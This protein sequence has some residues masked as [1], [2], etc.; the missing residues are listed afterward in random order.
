MKKSRRSFVRNLAAGALAAGVLP[1]IASAEKVH[2]LEWEKPVRKFSANDK[3]QVAAIGMGIMG[4]N[5]CRTTVQ[6]PGVELVATCDLYNGR[7]ERSKEVFGNHLFTTRNYKEILDRKDIDAVIVSTSDH[8]HDHI[9]IAALQA[10][11]SVYCEK[12]MVQHIEE[13][14][15]VI[16][17][18]K[19]SGKTLIVGSQGVSGLAQRK[20]R[21]LYESGVIGQ[22]ITAEAWNDRQS[23]TG[24]W[25]YSIPTDASEKTVDWEN[26]IGD[27]PR[28]PWDP[29]R[30]FRWRNYREYGTGVAGDLFVHLFSGLHNVLSSNGPERIYAA[31]GL[32]YWKDGRDAPDLI[33]AI[34][35]YPETNTHPAFNLQ[36]RVNFASGDGGGQ[37]TR[38]VGSD[39]VIELGWDGVTLR[40]HKVDKI[41]SYIGWDSYETF[42]TAQ[43]KEFAVWHKK[44]YPALPPEIV[45]PA[46]L[47]FKTP[48]GYDDHFDH[49]FN[50]YES[51]RTG[52]APV[53]D[54]VFGLRAAAPSLAANLSLFEQK[55]VKW[56]PVGMILK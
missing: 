33:M 51:M 6:V 47:V 38:L 20:A 42:S 8:W 24:A 55:V 10:G 19:K 34:L 1:K 13:G 36:L 5:N 31:G 52:K 35:D 37:K 2:M 40:K 7:L 21:E 43:Q 48:E 17:A 28:R 41:P 54:A 44:Q 29:V 15:A 45:E 23:A 26:F 4:F 53:E 46:E 27:A 50:F 39:G 12:P 18:Q 25:Q 11:K 16:E 32:R 56:D 22:L 3:V 9:S 14:K 49:H 30:F